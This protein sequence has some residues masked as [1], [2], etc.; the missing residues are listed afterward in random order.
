MNPSEREQVLKNGRDIFQHVSG[1]GERLILSA[2]IWVELKA[3]VGLLE[4][5]VEWGPEGK[6]ESTYDMLAGMRAD[7]DAPRKDNPG[8]KM[9]ETPQVKLFKASSIKPE[10]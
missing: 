8:G 4:E 2:A 7:L 9:V 10:G 1:V 5:L 3:Y 6:P